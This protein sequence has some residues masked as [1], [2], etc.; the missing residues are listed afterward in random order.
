MARDV[1]KQMVVLKFFFQ[2]SIAPVLQKR[3]VLRGHLSLFPGPCRLSHAHPILITAIVL[4][5]YLNPYLVRMVTSE[6]DICLL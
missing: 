2:L 5:L 3:K 1:E 4:H 6:A